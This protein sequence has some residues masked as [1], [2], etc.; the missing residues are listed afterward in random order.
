MKLTFPHMGNLSICL[1]SLFES[2]GFEVILPPPF[3]KRTLDLGVK[4]SPEFACFPFKINVGNYVEAIEKGA[5]T[6]LML[7]DVGPCR[8]GYYAQLQRRLLK[9]LDYDFDMIIV[10]SPE[11]SIKE[12]TGELAKLRNNN[13][14]RHILPQIYLTFKKVKA[15]DLVDQKT[16]E[17]RPRTTQSKKL[18]KIYAEFQQEMEQINNAKSLNNLT[19]EVIS[20]IDRLK[21][22]SFQPVKVALVGEI[23]MLLE[24]RANMEIE[25]KLGN[26]GAHVIRTIHLSDS[27]LDHIVLDRIG[28][29][30]RNKK[31]YQAAQPFLNHFVGGHG[32]ES[33][34]EA[35][36]KAKEGYDGVIHVMPFTCT[37]EIIAQNILPQVSKE[38][39]LP[40]LNVI[41][42]EHTGET[43]LRTRLEAFY[44]LLVRKNRERSA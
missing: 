38:Y 15:F 37:P 30:N 16:N 21:D 8:F 11:N 9:D 31:V 27:I 7:G 43:G 23:F 35:V 6:I 1:K 4:Y 5:D 22:K 42:D 3:T 36:L 39:N 12:L 13:T 33:V 41:L 24:F 10:Q 17:A 40:L 28:L 25:K 32:I 19:R 34:G 2:L 26:M 29:I 18:N 14:W 20:E 44:D